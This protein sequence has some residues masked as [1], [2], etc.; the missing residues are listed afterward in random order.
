VGDSRGAR[1]PN[2]LTKL[3]QDGTPLP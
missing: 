1:R 2:R 3:P